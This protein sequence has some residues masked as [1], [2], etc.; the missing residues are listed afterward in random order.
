MEIL[1]GGLSTLLLDEIRDVRECCGVGLGMGGMS[2]G[3]I[4]GELSSMLKSGI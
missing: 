4:C 3:G 2:S 1:S